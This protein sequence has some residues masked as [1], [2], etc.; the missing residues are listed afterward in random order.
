MRERR[1]GLASRGGGAERKMEVGGSNSSD[2][3]KYGN[4][5][6]CCSSTQANTDTGVCCSTTLAP[7]C[8]VDAVLD[9]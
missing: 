9:L 6:Y 3:T 8:V 7:R 5:R 2:G 4:F 1:A